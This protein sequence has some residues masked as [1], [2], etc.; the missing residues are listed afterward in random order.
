MR[1]SLSTAATTAL[2]LLSASNV[3]AQLT[4]SDVVTNINIVTSL[5]QSLQAPANQINILSPALFLIGQGPFPQ[6]IIGFGT[7]VND[8]SQD[9]VAMQT[10]VVF[11]GS[12]A[13][14][15]CNAY[16]NFIAVHQ[17]LLS[18]LIGK[19]GLFSDIPFI[20]APVAQAFREVE[21][22]VDTV[23]TSLGNM[24]PSCAGQVSSQ[25]NLLNEQL[26]QAITA[27]SGLQIKKRTSRFKA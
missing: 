27:Y 19:A 26:G 10:P 21:N 7:I 18:I 16:F 15:V 3:A 17:Q 9:I 5:S 8:V 20:G 2:T 6:I 14:I 22:V 25:T 24:V 1:F 23:A 11:T 12:D 13:T 4:A